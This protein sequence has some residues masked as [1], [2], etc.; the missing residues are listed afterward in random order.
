MHFDRVQTS[1]GPAVHGVKQLFLFLMLEQRLNE[2]A[3]GCLRELRLEVQRGHRLNLC[4]G[5]AQI[6]KRA[7]VD[8]P[9]AERLRIEHI[10]FIE[11]SFEDAQEARAFPLRKP[12]F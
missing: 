8:V 7:D 1:I 2:R 12:E 5:I 10:Y 3:K 4:V 9:K 6:P 11:A